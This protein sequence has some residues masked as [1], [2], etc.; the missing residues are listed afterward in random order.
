MNGIEGWDWL[1]I[2]IGA[3]VTLW[4]GWLNWRDWK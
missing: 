2:A 4:W 1:W 3:A